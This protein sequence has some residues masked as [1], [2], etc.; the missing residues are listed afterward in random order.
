MVTRISNAGY[1]DAP[2]HL[3]SKAYHI[4]IARG[5]C[6]RSGIQVADSEWL[7]PQQWYQKGLDPDGTTRRTRPLGEMYTAVKAQVEMYYNLV[8]NRRDEGRYRLKDALD[9]YESVYFLKQQPSW[10]LI[11]VPC[12]CKGFC[13]WAICKHYVL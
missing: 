1:K 3:K 12:N 9:L 2:L 5:D 13:K 8:I 4:D 7:M 10:G 6:E 11:P